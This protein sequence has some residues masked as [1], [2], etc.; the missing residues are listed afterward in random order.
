MA[1]QIFTDPPSPTGA[2]R[3]APPMLPE[4]LAAGIQ[5]LRAANLQTVRLQL[6]MFRQ[7]RRSAMESLDRL[8]DIDRELERHLAAF[9]PAA[10]ELEE[11]RQLV[12][13]QKSA[14][15][16]EKMALM[17]EISGPT[18]KRSRPLPSPTEDGTPAIHEQEPTPPPESPPKI[19]VASTQGPVDQRTERPRRRRWATAL[20]VFL[21]LALAVGGGAAGWLAYTQPALAADLWREASAALSSWSIILSNWIDSLPLP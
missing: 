15:A 1:S 6:A 20:V 16:N 7:E 2:T 3:A 4:D 21:L 17:A 14:L 12:A 9:E 18:V 8:A 19:I 10:T 13:A 5:L 11:V